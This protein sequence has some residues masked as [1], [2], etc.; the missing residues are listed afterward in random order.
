MKK[1]IHP[2]YYN[3][4]K[5]SCACGAVLETGSTIENMEVEICSNCHPFFS[6]KKKTIDTTGRVDRFKKLTEKSAAKKA[7]AIKTVK[8]KKTEKKPEKIK[9]IK[10]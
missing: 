4:A 3:E 1:G 7:A 6:G 2:K 8:E 9:A 5:I 10:K